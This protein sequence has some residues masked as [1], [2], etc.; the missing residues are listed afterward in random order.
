MG[1]LEGLSECTLWG[2]K[3]WPP[4][5]WLPPEGQEDLLDSSLPYT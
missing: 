2:G 5:S 1:L 3:G 4:G